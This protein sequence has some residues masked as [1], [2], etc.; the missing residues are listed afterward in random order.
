MALD[1]SGLKTDLQDAFET[2]LAGDSSNPSLVTEVAQMIA[3]AIV[4]YADQ[5]EY[6]LSSTILIPAAPSPTPSPLQKTKVKNM[7]AD[8]GSAAL[9]AACKAS[10]Q[11]KDKYA[12]ISAAIP[13]YIATFVQFGL[14]PATVTTV[15]VSGPPPNFQSVIDVG[16]A[17]EPD[18][19]NPEQAAKDTIP[20]IAEKMANEIHKTFSA[21]TVASAIVAT[22][23]HAQ[24]VSL[25]GPFV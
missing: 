22:P 10:L 17:V 2:G 12:A 20:K 8:A 11:N 23:P 14:G 15:C 3:F 25:P 7:T 4:A 24:P 5:L 19:E 1:E 13:V 21:S 16:L 9:F 18:P 6:E